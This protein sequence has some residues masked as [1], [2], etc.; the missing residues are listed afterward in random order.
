MASPRGGE[1][2]GSWGGGCGH[3]QVRGEGLDL[4]FLVSEEPVLRKVGVCLSV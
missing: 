2:G 1:K 4:F 3:S